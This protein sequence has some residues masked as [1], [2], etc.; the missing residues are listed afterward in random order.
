MPWPRFAPNRRFISPVSLSP[1]ERPHFQLS[2]VYRDIAVL[3]PLRLS[4]AQPRCILLVVNTLWGGGVSNLK[5]I[6]VFCGSSRGARPDYIEASVQLARAMAEQNLSLVY[7]GAHVG[8]MGAIANELLELGGKVYGVI[9]ES[10]V[11]ME[12]AHQGLTELYVVKDMHERKAKMTDLADGFISLPGGLGTLEEMFEVLTWA[13][14][15]FHDKPSG[16]LNVAGYYNDLLSFLD[17]ANNE[18]FMRRE[19][20]QLLIDE[21]EPEQLLARLMNYQPAFI[22]KLGPAA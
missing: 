12:V 9:P 8:I 5:S 18:G 16:L 2:Q 15:G 3:P 19:H 22:P 13:Q 21:S 7:G 11:E 14:L 20:R 10:L 6:C 1:H 4:A 17:H